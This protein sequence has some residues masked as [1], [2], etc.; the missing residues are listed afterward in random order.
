MFQK[1]VQGLPLEN[2]TG[3]THPEQQPDHP[4]QLATP[5][6]MLAAAGH[7]KQPEAALTILNVTVRTPTT[8]AASGRWLLLL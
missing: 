5:H 3:A 7:S 1:I 6:A 4:L 2:Q 8:T